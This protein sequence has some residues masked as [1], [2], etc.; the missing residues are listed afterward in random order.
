MAPQSP[1]DAWLVQAAAFRK[2]TLSFM[3][4][5]EA[6][7]YHVYVPLDDLLKHLAHT[8]S[9]VVQQANP[10]TRKTGGTASA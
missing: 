7:G 2:A 10:A 9:T 6:V 5:Q 1:Q 8:E 4:N 3:Q